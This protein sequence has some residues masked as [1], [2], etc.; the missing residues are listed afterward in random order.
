[1][2]AADLGVEAAQLHLDRHEVAA[3][4]AGVVE[5]LPWEIGERPQV[6]QSAAVML[7][8]GAPFARIY[9]P[10]A[11]RARVA[12]G[13]VAE[14]TVTGIDGVFEGHLRYVSS[15]A[16]FTPFFA[17]TEHDRGK[18]TY[19]AEVDLTGQEARELPTGLP[20]QVR[21]GGGAQK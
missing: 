20:V 14:I 8:N 9:M 15:D 16:V 13:T 1:M 21:L 17:L 3:P 11:M 6:G 2:R 5:A 7:A 12:A 10:Q 18:L 19:L 4:I